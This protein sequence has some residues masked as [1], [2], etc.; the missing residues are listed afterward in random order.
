MTALETLRQAMQLART[1]RTDDAIAMLS[2]YLESADP[3]SSKH[4]LALLARNAG[5][6]CDNASRLPECTKY[7]EEAL[8]LEPED[9]HTLL[10]L[11]DAF[12]RAGN[13]ERA[14]H[15]WKLFENAAAAS[16]STEDQE[17]LDWY[18]SR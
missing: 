15:Y 18:R 6:L 10:A 3:V 4:E 12:A 14:S 7:Y 11:G 2:Q 8:R 1:A 9:V 13:D 16:K 5:L 17:L